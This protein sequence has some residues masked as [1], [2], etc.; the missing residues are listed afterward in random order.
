M[1][2]FFR[3]DVEC[4]NCSKSSTQQVLGST[5]ALGSSDLDLRPPE[6]QRSTMSAWLQLCPHCGYV[7]P[8]LSR[9]IG[10]M[11]MVSREEY[12]GTLKDPRFPELAR[13]FLA[14]A[15]LSVTTEPVNAAH[16]RLRAAW[17]CDDSRQADL[18]VQCRRLAAECF[19][20]LKPFE[21]SE[22]GIT[23]GAVLVDVLRR[24]GEF[25]AAVAECDALL[26]CRQ[27]TGI[28][29][30]VLEYQ[31]RLAADHDATAHRVEECTR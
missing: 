14:H 15:L 26:A 7:A 3:K 28:L 25:D 10:D 29:R 24:A 8:D 9:P 30:Q 27:A 17:V 4:A 5:N 31:R 22:Q 1:T 18:A 6:M 11:A 19:T 12:Q 16:A 13:R 23:Q 21:D 2:T 20:A